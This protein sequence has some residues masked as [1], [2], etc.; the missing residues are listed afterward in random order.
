MTL[1][2]LVAA[3]RRDIKDTKKPY[4]VSAD[5][6]MRYAN[7]AQREAA[8][9]ARLLV[10]STSD[11]C[12]VAV[13]AG[14]AVVDIDPCIISI[15]RARLQSASRP[16]LKA[17][18]RDMDDHYAGWD[19]SSNTSTP[20]VVVVDYATDQLY[21]YPTPSTSDTLLL[22]VTRE[23]LEDMEADSSTPE[24]APRYHEALIAWMKYR[25]YTA[26]DS[27]LYSEAQA[28]RANAAFEAEFGPPTSAVN[29]RFDL[30]HYDDVGER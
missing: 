18:V 19:S 13:T 24:I 11:L 5:D 28:A 1:D 23:P 9:R 21:L 6:A 3:F 22:T 7:Q 16:L 12:Q 8:R 29:E 10:D 25:A 17:V 15:R 14:E 30:E 26:D 2:Q 27:D 20:Y 4:L